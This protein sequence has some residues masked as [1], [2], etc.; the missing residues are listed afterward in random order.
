MKNDHHSTWLYAAR[1]ISVVNIKLLENK[2]VQ[3]DII[4]TNTL[5]AENRVHN[6]YKTHTHTLFMKTT[7]Y[8][9]ATIPRLDKCS[10]INYSDCTG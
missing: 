6:Q 9:R 8:L 1:N 5:N 2:E 4:Y 3:H 7:I 10:P